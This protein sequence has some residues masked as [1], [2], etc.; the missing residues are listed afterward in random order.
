MSNSPCVYG[1]A[2]EQLTARWR[3]V[4]GKS[5]AYEV[6]MIFSQLCLGLF[7]CLMMPL[8]T[9]YIV[10]AALYRCTAAPKP[11]ESFAETLMRRD[12]A[13]PMKSVEAVTP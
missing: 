7:F 10:A 12:F 8:M 2:T 11:A 13:D 6:A 5:L 3:K 4:F 9:A 1:R